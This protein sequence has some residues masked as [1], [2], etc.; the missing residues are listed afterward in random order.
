MCLC[1]C[2]CSWWQD[3]TQ[4]VADCRRNRGCVG[5]ANVSPFEVIKRTAIPMALALITV[6]LATFV[7]FH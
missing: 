7:L 2:R 6:L 1:Y 5:V 4:R 3:R